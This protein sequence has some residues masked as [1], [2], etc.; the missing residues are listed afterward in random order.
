VRSEVLTAVNVNITVFWD[1][2]PYSLRNIYL[3]TFQRN[4]VASSGSKKSSTLEM[5]AYA[6][7]NI[8]T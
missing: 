3:L 2:T 5:K 7:L 1:V 4:L 6:P 8:D